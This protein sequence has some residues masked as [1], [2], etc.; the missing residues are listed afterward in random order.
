LNASRTAPTRCKRQARLS[1]A[2]D[3]GRGG[4]FAR[5]RV[6]RTY[7]ASSSS[8]SKIS[9]ALGGITPPAPRAP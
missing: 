1:A 5:G 3:A 2:E 8:T 6:D 7:P 4:S 9:V